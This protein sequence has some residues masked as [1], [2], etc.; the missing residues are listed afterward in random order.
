M[1]LLPLLLLLGCSAEYAPLAAD[2]AP[3]DEVDAAI[4]EWTLHGLSLAGCEEHV[5]K[6]VVDGDRLEQLCKVDNVKLEGC[7]RRDKA[8]DAPLLIVHE[9]YDR[10][11][12][13]IHE[14]AHWLGDCSGM[15]TD[16]GHEDERIWGKTGVVETAARNL[17]D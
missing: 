11:W 2:D 9:R 7:F 14:L 4:S 17:G 8:T 13:D 1:R 10:P 15:G 3:P 12:L 6:L 5:G 16:P